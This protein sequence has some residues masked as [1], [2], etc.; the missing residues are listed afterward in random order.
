MQIPNVTAPEMRLGQ[1]GFVGWEGH[2]EESQSSQANKTGFS[3]GVFQWV[4][5]ADGKSLKPGPVKV[6]IKGF[7]C[8][9]AKVYDTARAVCAKLNA[10]ETI[11]QKSISV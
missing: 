1:H 10:G 2:I 3:L 7:Y 5:K 11:L 4:L 8:D 6:R 9:A